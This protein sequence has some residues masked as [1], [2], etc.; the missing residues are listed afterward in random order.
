[1]RV[2]VGSIKLSLHCSEKYSAVKGVADNA[3]THSSL[4]VFG[5]LSKPFHKRFGTFPITTCT[6]T[7]MIPFFLKHPPSSPCTMYHVWYS[8]A[9]CR[10]ISPR[11]FAGKNGVLAHLWKTYSKSVVVCSVFRLQVHHQ[12]VRSNNPGCQMPHHV[13]NLYDRELHTVIRGGC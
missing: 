4:S 2:R 7:S 9:R 3:D 8:I 6:A 11:R 13:A 12:K 1:M 5:M 10:E